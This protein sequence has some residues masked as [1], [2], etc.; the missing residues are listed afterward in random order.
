M[1][2]VIENSS[3]QTKLESFENLMKLVNSIDLS[4]VKLKLTDA[5]EGQGWSNDYCD[6]VEYLYRRFLCMVVLH[7]TKSIVPTKDIDSFWHQHILDTRA[8]AEDCQKIFGKFIHHFPYLGMRGEEDAKLLLDC[9]EETK[10]IY[11]ELFGESYCEEK[12]RC[13]KCSCR[14]TCGGGRCGQK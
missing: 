5:D 14:S 3:F 11:L 4:M 2:S 6:D 8:Y 1:H 12:S 9:F 10:S 7:P 13:T